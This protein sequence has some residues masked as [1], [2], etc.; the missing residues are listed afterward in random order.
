MSVE[1][2]LLEDVDGLG[3][4]GDRI[5]AADGYA[6]NYLLPRQLAASVTPGILRS[7]EAKKLRLQKDHEERVGVAKAMADRISQISLT[8][9]VQ[10][11]EDDKLYGSIGPQQVSEALAAQGLTI[12]KNDILMPEHIRALGN[13][14]VDIKLHTEVQASLKVWVSRA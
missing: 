4:I 7:L 1:L 10:A 12:D 3:K 5:K 6:R 11:G 2:I 13:Y 14:A 9:P 8:I